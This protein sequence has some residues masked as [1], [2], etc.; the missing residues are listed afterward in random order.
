VS[1]VDVALTCGT[2]PKPEVLQFFEYLMQ[3]ENMA[4]YCAEQVAFPT[5]TGMQATDPALEGLVPYFTS[6]RLATYSDHNFPQGVNLNN[7]MQQFLIN[8]NIPAFVNR[9]NTQWDR[10]IARLN[11][12]M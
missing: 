12:T 3:Q 2:D 9:L 1:G 7:Y 10:V 4:A 8:R 5:L 6:Q 11:S